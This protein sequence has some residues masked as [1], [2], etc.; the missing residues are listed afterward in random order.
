MPD[1]GVVT[2]ADGC[3]SAG[4]GVD[5]GCGVG[6]AA[7]VGGGAGVGVAVAAGSDVV[8]AAGTL[9]AVGRGAVVEV[10]AGSVVAVGA[11]LASADCE[12]GAVADMVAGLPV[13]AQAMMKISAK[14]RT[15][16]ARCRACRFKMHPSRLCLRP[17]GESNLPSGFPAGSG[18]SAA[19]P[20][21][22]VL[23]P[24]Q[25]LFVL[26]ALHCRLRFAGNLSDRQG[27]CV[28]GSGSSVPP[29][30]TAWR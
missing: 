22:M 27:F 16:G 10:T 11:G 24:V 12:A 5:V 14:A 25:T 21:F 9:V 2:P 8:V 15:A 28:P 3:G 18:V 7:G 19:R 6:E 23:R 20:C 13:S 26:L 4:A 30:R 17:V 1:G 29:R